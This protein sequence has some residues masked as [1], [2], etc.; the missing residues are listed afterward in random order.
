MR[1]PS[2]RIESVRRAGS[3][4]GE[5]RSPSFVN[6]E[7]VE[8]TLRAARPTDEEGWRALWRGYS[9]FY[10]RPV[11]EPVTAE[12]WRRVRSPATPYSCIV[13]CLDDAVVDFV[14]CV[15]H[16]IT[17]SRFPAC[18]LEDL[19]VSSEARGRGIGRL[20]IEDALRE[21]FARGCSRVYSMTEADNDRARALYDTFT[22][23]DGFVLYA[24]PLRAD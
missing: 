17:S 13:A 20:L 3:F 11:P 24:V 5:A 19:F 16:P 23:A 15:D 7:A 9:D 1:R 14:I 22:V 2:Q 18:H 6:V 8:E 12:T 21:A 4:C 10:R